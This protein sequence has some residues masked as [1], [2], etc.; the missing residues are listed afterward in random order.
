MIAEPA[1]FYLFGLICLCS[2]NVASSFFIHPSSPLYAPPHFSESTSPNCVFC[3]LSLLRLEGLD[4][5]KEF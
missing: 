4:P 1:H 2:G 5:C 3:D